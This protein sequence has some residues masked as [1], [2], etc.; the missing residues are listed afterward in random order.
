MENTLNLHLGRCKLNFA[1]VATTK[2]FP[3]VRYAN[4]KMAIATFFFTYN[5]SYT[6]IGAGAKQ[7][8]NFSHNFKKFSFDNS[9][10]K[11]SP[12]FKKV[13]LYQ[14]V[15]QTFLYISIIHTNTQKLVLCK[16]SKEITFKFL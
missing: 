3:I 12:L 14:S 4:Q 9:S 15:D 8:S 5:G 13:L 1:N 11:N 7:F 10:L 6:V 2:I 16:N